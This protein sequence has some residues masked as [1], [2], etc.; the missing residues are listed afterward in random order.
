MGFLSLNAGDRFT[1][2]PVAA[3]VSASLTPASV[4]ACIGESDT[5]AEVEQSDP[6]SGPET[7]ESDLHWEKV[8]QSRDTF[9]ITG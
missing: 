2:S 9:V 4:T 8:T 5:A 3:D 1:N 6:D 7:S